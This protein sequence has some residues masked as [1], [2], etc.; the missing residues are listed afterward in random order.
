[1]HQPMQ[2]LRDLG[3]SPGLGRS[4]GWRHGNPLQYSCLE[5]PMGRGAWKATVHRVTKSR[6]QLKWVGMP[7]LSIR[8]SHPLTSDVLFSI[9]VLIYIFLLFC[10]YNYQL[11][12]QFKNFI[13]LKFVFKVYFWP[14][15]SPFYYYFSLNKFFVLNLLL[16]GWILWLRNFFKEVLISVL[17]AKFLYV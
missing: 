9:H 1:M 6:R 16:D 2:D 10:S 8:S 5:N 17:F 12:N 3:S 13:H 4:P 15:T 7:A 11:L 14:I